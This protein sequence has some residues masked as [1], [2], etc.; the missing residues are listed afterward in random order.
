M[1]RSISLLLYFSQQTDDESEFS[2][3]RKIEPRAANLILYEDTTGMTED[4]IS[5]MEIEFKR[6]TKEIKGEFSRLLLRLQQ[7]LEKS[8]KV[9]HIVNLL[10]NLDDEDWLKKCTSIA[11][12]FQ[13]AKKFCSFYD[14]KAVKLLIEELGTEQDRKNYENYKRKF[15][16]FCLN[17][18]FCFPDGKSSVEAELAMKTDKHI[19]KLSP[20]EK[21]ELQYEISRVFKGKKPVRLF[22]EKQFGQQSASHLSKSSSP[23]KDSSEASTLTTPSDIGE[24]SGSTT[25]KPSSM[26]DSTAP[27]SIGAPSEASSSTTSKPSGMSTPSDSTSIGAPSEASITSSKASSEVSSF[28]SH[29]KGSSVAG[30]ENNSFI[31][32][33][34][35]KPARKKAIVF[36]SSHSNTKVSTIM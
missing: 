23:N 26:S 29:S 20:K 32:K 27:S 3:L 8:C 6:E 12:V 7:S 24:A 17:R 31:S 34:K 33:E 36:P 25:S 5:M 35:T 22:S 4:K 11:E 30:T 19:E 14:N 10:I 28:A 16:S 15:R 18:V 9:D 1:K 21:K 2:G 13:N